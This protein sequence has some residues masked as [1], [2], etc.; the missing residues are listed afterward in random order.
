V[1]ICDRI[2]EKKNILSEGI[3]RTGLAPPSRHCIFVPSIQRGK[4]YRRWNEH[5]FGLEGYLVFHA[6]NVF[7]AVRELSDVSRPSTNHG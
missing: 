5:V 3:C 7:G 2:E 4:G 6:K 1:K